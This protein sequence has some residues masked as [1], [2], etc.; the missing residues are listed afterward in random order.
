MVNICVQ[1]CK[2]HGRKPLIA[3]FPCR[4]Q[5]TD[6]STT[7]DLRQILRFGCCCCLLWIHIFISFGRTVKSWWNECTNMYLRC[8]SHFR[9]C[10]RNQ[11][12]YIAECTRDDTYEYIFLAIADLLCNFLFIRTHISLSSTHHRRWCLCALSLTQSSSSTLSTSIRPF[13]A[14]LFVHRVINITKKLPNP[15]H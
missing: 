3:S 12:S 1:N 9:V 13:V 15:I 4:Q 6:A 10:S 11:Y 14:V 2:F 5:R 7:T 8:A